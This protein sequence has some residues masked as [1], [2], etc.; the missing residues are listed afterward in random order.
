[1]VD[2]RHEVRFSPLPRT[3]FAPHLAFCP[4]G[5]LLA[6]FTVGDIASGLAVEVGFGSARLVPLMSKASVSNVTVPLGF[7]VVQKA[8]AIAR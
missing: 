7:A 1:M 5:K 6:S 3:C 8:F 2:T 4:V